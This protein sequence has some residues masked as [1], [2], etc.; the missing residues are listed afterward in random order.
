MTATYMYVEEAGT[1][2]ES[3]EESYTREDAQAH[4]AQH[5]GYAQHTVTDTPASD[6]R[7][8]SLSEL[9]HSKV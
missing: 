9:L 3:S 5:H 4:E 6:Y 7:P 1:F 2:S 8:M